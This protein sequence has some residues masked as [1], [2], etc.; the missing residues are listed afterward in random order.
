MDE[1]YCLESPDIGMID[2]QSA[3]LF[4]SFLR[5]NNITLKDFITHKKYN[6]VIDGDEYCEF[7]KWVK[8]GLI[9]MDNIVECYPKG[10]I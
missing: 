1:E 5:K 3:G 7:Q 9:N 2:H 6:I 8:K 10:N 4:S